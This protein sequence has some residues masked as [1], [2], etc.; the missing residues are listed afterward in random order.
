[1]IFNNPINVLDIGC[2]YQEKLFENWTGVDIDLNAIQYQKKKFSKDKWIWSDFTKDFNSDTQES[3]LTKN[4]YNYIN[5]DIFDQHYN[6]IMLINCLHYYQNDES[7]WINL[8][9]NILSKSSNNTKLIIRYLDK[10]KLMT[11]FENS[12]I[13]E[14]TNDNSYVKKISNNQIE[15]FYQWNHKQPRIEYLVDE[16]VV[17]KLQQFGWYISDILEDNEIKNSDNWNNYFNC[18]KT[19]VFRYI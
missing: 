12:N 14:N 2:G 9:N 17:N 4:L 6:C 5:K 10:T 19:I 8:N 15:I 3:I 11:L 13:I 1:M 16:T 18:F 7:K